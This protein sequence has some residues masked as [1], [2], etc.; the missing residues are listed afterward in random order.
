MKTSEH[1][2]DVHSALGNVGEGLLSSEM[3]ARLLFFTHISFLFFP[4]SKQ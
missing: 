4:L 2:T 3:R 1:R